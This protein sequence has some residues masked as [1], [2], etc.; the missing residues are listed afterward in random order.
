MYGDDKKQNM[1]FVMF[2][3]FCRKTF[4]QMIV[5]KRGSYSAINTP[6]ALSPIL[7]FS[8]KTNV[9][10]LAQLIFFFWMDIGTVGIYGKVCKATQACLPQKY[11]PGTG[12]LSAMISFVI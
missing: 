11:S 6:A 10:F 5:D 7:C 2:Y 1:T 8:V 4:Q 9:F 12:Y 3:Q